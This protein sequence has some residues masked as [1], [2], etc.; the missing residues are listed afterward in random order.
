[1][2]DPKS[3]HPEASYQTRLPEDDTN[4]SRKAAPHPCSG[5]PQKVDNT[6]NCTVLTACISCRVLFRSVSPSSA[7]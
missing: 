1:V 4:A 6:I 3:I 7:R 5:L 2:A